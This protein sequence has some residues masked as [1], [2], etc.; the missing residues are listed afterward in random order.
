MKTNIHQEKPEYYLGLIFKSL[1]YWPIIVLAISISVGLALYKSLTTIPTYKIQTKILVQDDKNTDPQSII[2]LID[3]NQASSK[4]NNEIG[5][6]HSYEFIKRVVSKL[7]FEVSVFEEQQY[8]NKRLYPNPYFNIKINKLAPQPISH[9]FKLTFV[10]DSSIL[11][12]SVEPGANIYQYSSEQ[13]IKSLPSFQL[14]TIINFNETLI[15]HNFN[16]TIEIENINI[17]KAINK[18]FYFHFNSTHNLINKFKEFN[19]T[20]EEASSII[21]ISTLTDNKLR[22]TTFLNALSSEYLYKGIERKNKIAANTTRFIDNQISDIHD[23]LYQSEKTIQTF[24]HS[25]GGFNMDYKTNYIYNRLSALEEQ[26]TNIDVELKYYKYLDQFMTQNTSLDEM[27]MPSSLKIDN[28]YLNELLN[29]LNQ[30]LFEH[31]EIKSRTLQE[32]PILSSTKLKAINLKKAI[33]ETLIT[34]KSNLTHEKKEI[35]T[36]IYKI[37]T[38]LNYLPEDQQEY[39]GLQRKYNINEELYTFLLTRRAEMEIMKASNIP[40]SE[41][42]DLARTDQYALIE[43]IIL[44]IVYRYLGLGMA[45][46][47]G[48]IFIL[49]YFNDKVYENKDIENITNLPILGHILHNKHKSNFIVKEQPQSLITESFRA[50]RTNIDLNQKGNGKIIL[51]S[52][53]NISE[54][55]SFISLNLAAS[56]ALKNCKTV[57][58]GLD[59]RKPK[60]NNYLNIDNSN[61]G[62][63]FFYTNQC[64]INDI[65]EHTAQSNLDFIPF[66]SIPPNPSELL[67]QKDKNEEL[68]N[69]LRNNYDSIILDTSPLGRVTDT[70]LLL[71]YADL[72]LIITRHNSTRIRHLKNLLNELNKKG[73]KNCGIVINDIHIKSNKYGYGPGYGYG[74]GYGYSNKG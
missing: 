14:D 57:I 8:I 73:I 72:N 70:R 49:L 44:R 6:L 68:F 65:I 38:E 40:S 20:Q 25:K 11:I 42:L 53:N 58:V 46:A 18:C 32:T 69:H 26:L 12:K 33:S 29:Q 55:K 17:K 22:G 59:L 51:I 4:I 74:Y 63:S 47:A 39:I 5:I 43:P 35:N 54:G 62:L 28:P 52:S 60:I 71:G 36:R 23:S 10:S 27:V 31:G 37:K 21:I 45:I 16:F 56:F 64:K 41:I 50:L 9:P 30:A 15:S 3:I 48:I 2:G 19:V 7:N 24:I 1:K 66:G 34:A 61:S 13:S 67:S